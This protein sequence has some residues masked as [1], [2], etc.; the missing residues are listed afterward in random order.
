MSQLSRLPRVLSKISR[1]EV[2]CLLCAPVQAVL[3]EGLIASH[4]ATAAAGLPRFQKVQSLCLLSLASPL[5]RHQS[6]H[7]PMRGQLYSE[8]GPR[9]APLLLPG[10]VTWLGRVDLFSCPSMYDTLLQLCIARQE[11]ANSVFS[12]VA[13]N[14]EAEARGL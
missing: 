8:E 3:Q 12:S 9:D 13:K 11:R 4:H 10:Q 14:L 1:K 5:W 2:L 6:W 7:G